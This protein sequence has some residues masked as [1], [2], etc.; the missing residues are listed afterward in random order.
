MDY[1]GTPRKIPKILYCPP[2]LS[3]L[4]HTRIDLGTTVRT[5]ERSNCIREVVV[6]NITRSFIIQIIFFVLRS[7]LRKL[8]TRSSP[9]IILH[10]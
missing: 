4:V 8:S 9:L 10:T 2:Q 7:T 5:N 3:T 1:G 6:A